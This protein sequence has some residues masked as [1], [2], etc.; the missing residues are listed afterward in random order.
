MKVF[1]MAT[2]DIVHTDCPPVEASVD[3]RSLYIKTACKEIVETIWPSIDQCHI[4]EA[5]FDDKN[6]DD[7]AGDQTYCVCDRDKGVVI[8]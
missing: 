3:E 4:Y 1:G 2:R 7:N 8:F 5:C 6:D